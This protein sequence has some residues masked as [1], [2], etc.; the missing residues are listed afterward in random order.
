M[1]P[2]STRRPASAC[3]WKSKAPPPKKDRCRCRRGGKKFQRASLSAF[4][5]QG[6]CCFRLQSRPDDLQSRSKRGVMLAPEIAR[7]FAR[8]AWHSPVDANGAPSSLPVVCAESPAKLVICSL[9]GVMMTS[10]S[11][12]SASI[13]SAGK[14]GQSSNDQRERGKDSK[15]HTN[16][17]RKMTTSCGITLA[18]IRVGQSMGELRIH[19]KDLH[20]EGASEK[21]VLGD[22]S[23]VDGLTDSTRRAIRA[24]GIR[25]DRPALRANRKD[26]RLV[27]ARLPSGI[28]DDSLESPDRRVHYCRV[29]FERGDRAGNE[30]G[31]TNEVRDNPRLRATI[32]VLGAADLRDL[33]TLENR[34]PIGDGEGFLLVMGDVNG[35]EA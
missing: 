20:F 30:V 15:C 12:A 2:L 31:F 11:S 5:R 22:L 18:K 13:L 28:A 34:H 27:R 3:C 24:P 19:L 10:V 6:R 7:D 21:L 9:C 16:Q 1:A 23:Q 8:A 29:L 33:A 17:T 26:H 4:D 25:V 32:N 14:C 35:R